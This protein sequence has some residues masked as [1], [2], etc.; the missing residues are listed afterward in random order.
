MH[1]WHRYGWG[2]G[3]VGEMTVTAACRDVGTAEM[4]ITVTCKVMEL[5]Y[6]KSWC[7]LSTSLGTYLSSLVW[8]LRAEDSRLRI[9]SNF[10]Y[11][12]FFPSDDVT[13]TKPTDA[14]FT[15]SYAVLNNNIED[16][17]HYKT[18]EI[19]LHCIFMFSLTSHIYLYIHFNG[20]KTN[21][22]KFTLVSNLIFWI[23]LHKYFM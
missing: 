1:G 14:G 15:H 20:S 18:N 8:Q 13:T 5:R 9:S 2:M 17:Q 7:V 19:I 23:L 22:Y 10:P 16:K 3:D 12:R 21:K 4:R 6:C 11:G